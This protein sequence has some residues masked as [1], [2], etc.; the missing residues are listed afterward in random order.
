MY[1]IKYET[2][3]Q[4]RFNAWYWMLGAGT[5]GRPRGMVQGGRREEGSGW[6]TR[7]YL[8]Q[9]HVD[10]WQNQYNI[11]KLK[12]K[13]MTTL[14]PSG[15][16]NQTWVTSLEPEQLCL[17]RLDAPGAEHDVHPWSSHLRPVCTPFWSKAQSPDPVCP[18]R[19]QIILGQPENAGHIG[20]EELCKAGWSA[21]LPLWGFPPL[22]SDLRVT[23]PLEGGTFRGANGEVRI[24]LRVGMDWRGWTVMRILQR[25]HSPLA[26][27]SG[28]YRSHLQPSK[29]IFRKALLPQIEGWKS[30]SAAVLCLFLTATP[31]NLGLLGTEY[32]EGL[33]GCK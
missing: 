9:I 13:K 32:S 5:L 6:T 23:L 25:K 12:K 31:L 10:I 22:A 19:I 17:P 1:N 29:P 24:G 11:V 26:V 28:T 30:G 33:R 8:W 16:G 18:R 21:L 7:V 20:M 15:L 3:R 4:S 27:C 2:S 14:V